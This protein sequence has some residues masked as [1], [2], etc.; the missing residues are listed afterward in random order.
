MHVY[1]IPIQTLTFQLGNTCSWTVMVAYVCNPRLRQ[2]LKQTNGQEIVVHFCSP[3]IQE[4]DAVG[5]LAASSR[6]T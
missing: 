4:D 6:P 2:E 1:I 5:P 3:S